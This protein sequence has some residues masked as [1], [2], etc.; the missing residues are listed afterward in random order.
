[1]LRTTD[2]K[3]VL[4]TEASHLVAVV[5]ALRQEVAGQHC[6]PCSMRGPC[7][8][9]P[10]TAAVLASSSGFAKG[11]AMPLASPAGF[12]WAKPVPQC[13]GHSS[14]VEHSLGCCAWATM[15]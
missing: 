12:D 15:S 6:M 9:D 1:M 8:Q 14:A 3:H 4:E 13:P 7:S 2:V 5:V 10:G 11:P